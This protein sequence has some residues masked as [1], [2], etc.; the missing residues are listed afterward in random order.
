M[1]LDETPTEGLSEAQLE[2][3][4]ADTLRHLEEAQPTDTARDE[5]AEF[6]VEDTDIAP[7]TDRTTRSRARTAARKP[8][9]VEESEAESEEEDLSQEEEAE[10][11]EEE[12]EFAV[13]KILDCRKKRGGKREFFIKWE[14]YPSSDN[15]WEAE[16]NIATGLVSKWDAA[17]ATSEPAEKEV[18]LSDGCGGGVFHRRC[19]APR[20]LCGRKHPSSLTLSAARTPATEHQAGCK[21]WQGQRQ[22]QEGRRRARRRPAVV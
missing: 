15:T 3:L 16:A 10:E 17:H 9:V 20:Q 4:R 5:A 22:G 2:Q 1:L 18:C 21:A 7:A 19:V 12:E 6:G 11:E 13:E 8:V 14:G